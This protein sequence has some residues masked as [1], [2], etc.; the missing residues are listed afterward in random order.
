MFFSKLNQVELVTTK[1]VT[2]TSSALPCPALLLSNPD[3][4]WPAC[5][6][7][8]C[9]A[10]PCLFFSALLCPALALPCPALPCQVRKDRVFVNGVVRPRKVA[11]YLAPGDVLAPNPALGSSYQAY[12]CRQMGP[13]MTDVYRCGTHNAGRGG[14][15][16]LRSVHQSYGLSDAGVQG[17]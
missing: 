6:S 10:L 1:L 13:L 5:S 7:L 9:P 14:G 16:R 11:G 3:L 17:F 8:P 2:T 12:V 15:G 4:P